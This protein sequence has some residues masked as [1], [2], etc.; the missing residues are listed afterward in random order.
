LT[1]RNPGDPLARHQLVARIPL[2][3]LGSPTEVAAVIFYLCSAQ[4]SYVAGAEIP[5]NAARTS[6]ELV[7]ASAP[8]T[9]A[10]RCALPGPGLVP[11][12]RIFG[13]DLMKIAPEGSGH[14]SL[15]AAAEGAC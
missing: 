8:S 6:T 3:R 7:A 11:E 5:V 13:S 15:P 1:C 4:A 2:R 14:L 9:S 12:R 10:F